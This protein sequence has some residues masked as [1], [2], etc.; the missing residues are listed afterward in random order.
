MDPDLIV[1]FGADRSYPSHGP[2]HY[3]IPMGGKVR[4]G[5][6][7]RARLHSMVDVASA[8][9]QLIEAEDEIPAWCLD[10]IADSHAKLLDVYG[11]I[12]PRAA[13]AF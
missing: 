2:M 3:I 13:G 11:Y 6:M 1:V 7:A 12:E 4:S 9:Y 10:F 5:K 8:M